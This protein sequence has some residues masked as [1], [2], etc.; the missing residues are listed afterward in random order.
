M[1]DT[2]SSFGVKAM[3]RQ[4]IVSHHCWF[5]KREDICEY[6]SYRCGS[7]MSYTNL[8]PK[9]INE[10]RQKKVIKSKIACPNIFLNMYQ[11]LRKFM[12]E[13]IYVNV[14]NA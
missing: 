1:I 6:L 2:L 12:T 3:L 11:I 13:N 10:K 7:R 4:D 14:K 5:E 9:S 8:N